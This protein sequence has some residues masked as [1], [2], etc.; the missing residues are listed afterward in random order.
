MSK[1]TKAQQKRMVRDIQAKAGKLFMT[2]G[3]GIATRNSQSVI[4]VKEFAAID[5][6][7]KAAMRRIG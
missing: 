2:F 7:C 5:K 6:I 3:G 4:S 1:M